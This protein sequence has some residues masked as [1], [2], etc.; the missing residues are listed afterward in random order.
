MGRMARERE[1]V[2]LGSD[3]W[4]CSSSK[5]DCLNSVFRNCSHRGSSPARTFLTFCC[6]SWHDI[7]SFSPLTQQVSH[8]FHGP[9]DMLEK[10]LV[11]GA[12][13]VET[14][15]ALRSVDKTIKIGRAHV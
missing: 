10:C 4:V 1:S 14:G 11:P 2:L 8:D 12:K 5:F 3:I 15:L 6:Q 9:V 13:I 7:G